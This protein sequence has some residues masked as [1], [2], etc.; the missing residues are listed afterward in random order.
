M[1]IEVR[2]FAMLRERARAGTVE[3]EVPEGASVGDVIEALGDLVGET[4]VIAALN[5]EYVGREQTVSAGDELA[6]VPPVSGGVDAIHVRMSE[7]PLDAAALTE[8]VGRPAA[9]AVVTFQGVTREVAQLDYEAY[10]EMALARLRTIAE[11]VLA[12]TGA[13]AIAIEHRVGRV[14]LGEP[15]V[16][17][18]AS[19][20]HREQAFAA[21]REGIDRVKAEAP[22][23]KRE[24]GNWVEG[25][26][27]SSD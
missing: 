27:P 3:V 26:L 10:G 7:A 9:G 1:V 23:W 14:P 20:P 25:N 22:I 13:C 4:P 18:A 21:A 15:S 12:A 6:L 24:E 11:E 5:R 16:V 19:G 2:L 17:V 8:L